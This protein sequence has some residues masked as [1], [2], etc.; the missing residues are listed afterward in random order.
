[1]DARDAEDQK[2]LASLKRRGR[3]RCHGWYACDKHATRHVCLRA[4]RHRGQ[5]RFWWGASWCFFIPM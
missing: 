5:H 4:R 1:M 3:T 2:R